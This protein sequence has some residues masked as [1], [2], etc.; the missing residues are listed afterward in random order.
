LITANSSDA[1]L[2]ISVMSLGPIGRLSL[3]ADMVTRF[4][5]ASRAVVQWL[6]VGRKYHTPQSA[7]PQK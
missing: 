2:N 1:S 5:Q 7:M 6:K 3:P 4:A